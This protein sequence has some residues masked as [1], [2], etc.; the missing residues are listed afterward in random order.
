MDF[1]ASL[2]VGLLNAP[3]EIPIGCATGNC[4]FP[5]EAASY[6]TLGFESTSVDV[7]SEIRSYMPNFSQSLAYYIP[8]IGNGSYVSGDVDMRAVDSASQVRTMGVGVP[9]APANVSSYFP[10]Y[11]V[12]KNINSSL[13]S[14]ASLVNSVDWDCAAKLGPAAN[15]D[16]EGKCRKPF[17]TECKIWPA[18]QDIR[19]SV[20]ISTLEETIISSHPLPF[21]RHVYN[22]DW[23]ALPARILSNGAWNSC[24]ASTVYQP[25][26]PVATSNNTVVV[27]N[28]NY[29]TASKDSLWYSNDCVWHVDFTSQSA[30]VAALSGMF[31]NKKIG[32]NY[33]SYAQDL[34]GDLWIKMIYH[35]GTANLTTMEA[36]AG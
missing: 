5:I 33:G 9:Y 16:T 17:A 25:S 22:V 27:S 26:N 18:I 2:Y 1:A 30:L 10:E 35:N 29:S 3:G 32:G 24:S 11:W 23:L 34:D 36:Y 13:F 8:R 21:Y 31:Y 14:I 19:A 4:T 28:G 6:Q 15:Y 20:N 7:S 12:T